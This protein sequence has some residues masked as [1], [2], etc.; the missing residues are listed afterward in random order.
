MKLEGQAIGLGHVGLRRQ[1]VTECVGG[2]LFGAPGQGQVRRNPVVGQAHAA[3]RRDVSPERG[4]RCVHVGCPLAGE[5]QL[6]RFQLG[7]LRHLLR[8]HD[9]EEGAD[10]T[11]R[12]QQYQ[13]RK[14][15]SAPIDPARRP[16]HTALRNRSWQGHEK[17]TRA[18]SLLL[19]PVLVPT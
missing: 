14:D 16:E 18:A 15:P 8:Q 19:P 6:I 1:D 13:K 2:S 5:H 4:H 12:Q 7:Q 17:V 10:G 3:R 9:L 11:H